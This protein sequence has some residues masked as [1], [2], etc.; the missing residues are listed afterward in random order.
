MN[1]KL[2]HIKHVESLHD[3]SIYEWDHDKYPYILDDDIYNFFNGRL[4]EYIKRISKTY[5]N[6][7]ISYFG[8][9]CKEDIDYVDDYAKSKGYEE[10]SNSEYEDIKDIYILFPKEKIRDGYDRIIKSMIGV[11]LYFNYKEAE[12]A[13]LITG[14]DNV[15]LKQSYPIINVG[16]RI[17]KK[18]NDFRVFDSILGDFIKAEVTVRKN[19]KYWQR[20]TRL[21][22]EQLE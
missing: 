7:M 4:P 18:D 15:I 20:I 12:I 11:K 5:S 9:M 14:N 22:K 19:K 1:T 2:P 8:V 3:D 6:F 10:I 21:T 13:N 16:Y 17:Y